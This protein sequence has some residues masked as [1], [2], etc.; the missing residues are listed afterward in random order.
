M[1]SRIVACVCLLAFS[2]VNLGE[3][4]KADEDQRKMQGTW[5]VAQIEDDKPGTVVPKEELQKMRIVI[6]GN[7]L[8]FW[9]GILNQPAAEFKLDPSKMPRTI[10]LVGFGQKKDDQGKLR[11]NPDVVPAIYEIQDDSLRFCL[12]RNEKVPRP[13]EFKMIEGKQTLLVLERAKEEKP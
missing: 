9:K 13:T 1:L 3:D 4:T 5:R 8:Q 2:S 6:R 11:Q 7:K 12:P 10:D